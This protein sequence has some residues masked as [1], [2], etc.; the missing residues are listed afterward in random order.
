MENEI[1]YQGPFSM[2]VF[3]VWMYLLL[4]W[5]LAVNNYYHSLEN[6]VDHMHFNSFACSALIFFSLS[7]III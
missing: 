5:L 3:Q 4:V 6:I 1:R 7:I 2:I